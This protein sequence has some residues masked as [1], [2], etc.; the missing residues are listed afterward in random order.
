MLVKPSLYNIQHL[1]FN[2]ECVQQVQV[3]RG[4]VQVKKI[5]AFSCPKDCLQC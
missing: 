3:G 2:G 5:L 4:S 1:K